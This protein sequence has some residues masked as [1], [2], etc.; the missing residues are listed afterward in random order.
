MTSYLQ[1]IYESIPTDGLQEEEVME[2]MRRSQARNY[3]LRISGVLLYDG[4]HF[5]QLIE[6]PRDA[7]LEL[8]DRIAVDTR[9]RHVEVLDERPIATPL[10]A[11]WAMAYCSPQAGQ[12]RTGDDNFVLDAELARKLCQLLP[13]Y[14]G[15]HFLER[16][17]A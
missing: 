5:L 10:M 3:D 11:T 7:V 15:R 6:G 16:L 4:E 17:P 1:L 14:I 9:H 8:F 13:D 2:I 12:L